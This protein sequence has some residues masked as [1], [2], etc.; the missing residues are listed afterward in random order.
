M[1]LLQRLERICRCESAPLLACVLMHNVISEFLSGNLLWLVQV[2]V[3]ARAIDATGKYVMPGGIDPHTHLSMP[4]MGTIS[5][6]D[7][8]SGQSAAL[9]GGTT[10]HIDFALPV[11]G[12]LMAGFRE[13]QRKAERAVMPYGW[14]AL[15]SQCSAYMVA[16]FGVDRSDHI[17]YSVPHHSLQSQCANT[18]E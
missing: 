13:W 5:C 12:D 14:C 18:S 2:P 7:Y 10:M 15:E 17:I 11:D 3:G 8:F 16:G 4:A 6:E 1:A 9:S